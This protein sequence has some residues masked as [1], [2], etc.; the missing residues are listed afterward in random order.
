MFNSLTSLLHSF[1]KCHYVIV[2]RC[3]ICIPLKWNIFVITLNELR[4]RKILMNIS[5]QDVGLK[6]EIESYS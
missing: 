3:V 6:T 4:K 1:F 2:I 5:L